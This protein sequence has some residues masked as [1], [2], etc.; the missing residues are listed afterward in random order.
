MGNNIYEM[1][2]LINHSYSAYLGS[3]DTGGST[4][5]Q[6]GLLAEAAVGLVVRVEGAADASADG[7]TIWWSQ[8]EH[9]VAEG[10]EPVGVVAGGVGLAPDGGGEGHQS[11]HPETGWEELNAAVAGD[12]NPDAL[13]VGHAASGPVGVTLPGAASRHKNT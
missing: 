1:R 5:V 12:H 11:V 7:S 8:K 13:V 9:A 6:G 4:L 2:V 3:V 10:V